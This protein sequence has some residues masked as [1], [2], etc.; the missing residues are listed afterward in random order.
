LASTCPA[1]SPRAGP[2]PPAWATGGGEDYE[3]LLTCSPDA[4][5][6]LQGALADRGGARL[7]PIGEVTAGD[8]SVRWTSGG[9]EVTVARGYEHFAGRSAASGAGS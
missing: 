6:R 4:L 5:A 8:G 2:P 7:T 9:R 3:L 1:C